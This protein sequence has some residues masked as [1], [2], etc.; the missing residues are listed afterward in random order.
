MSEG[1][2]FDAAGFVLAGGESSRMGRDKALVPFAGQPLIAR[3]LALLRDAGFSASIAG[4][5]S[6][7]TEFAPIVEDAHT[8]LGPLSGICAA[9]A[10]TSAR[11]AV[12]LPVD[13]PLLPAPLL[14]YLL[15]HAQITGRAVTLPAINGFA[16][17]FPAV[18]D[19]AILPALQDELAAGHRGCFAAFRSAASALNEPVSTVAV[20]LL[21]QAGCVDHP[22][23]LPAARWFLNVNSPADLERAARIA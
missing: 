15:H 9:L 18:L 17:T 2:H 8:G 13:L 22:S 20:E 19:R 16:Q 5:R 21:V 1:Q 3:A 12:F 7:L 11:H 4:A 10:G 14:R 6:H 23:G